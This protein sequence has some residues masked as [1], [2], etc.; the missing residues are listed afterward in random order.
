MTWA[1]DLARLRALK[2]R[3]E[4]DAALTPE[5]L[6]DLAREADALVRSA[7]AALRR[8][9]STAGLL[10]DGPGRSPEGGP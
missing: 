4:R 1:E 10:E 8:A 2:E 9:A 3:L 5:Q 7:R 6:E